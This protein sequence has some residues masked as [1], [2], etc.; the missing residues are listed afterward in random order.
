MAIGNFPDFFM[1]FRF[2][3]IKNYFKRNELLNT[4]NIIIFLP[5]FSP[6][7]QRKRLNQSGPC[8]EKNYKVSQQYLLGLYLLN[9]VKDNVIFNLL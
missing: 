9:N 5:T 4:Y 6:E 2:F 8:E 1:N 3:G 7:D